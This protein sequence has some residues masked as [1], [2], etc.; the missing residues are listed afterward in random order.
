MV[1]GILIAPDWQREAFSKL[2]RLFKDASLLHRERFHFGTFF[3]PLDATREELEEIYGP[4]VIKEAK[5][6][7]ERLNANLVLLYSIGAGC[8]G[9]LKFEANYFSLQN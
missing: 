2:H 5:K 7:G 1:E 4:T 8:P 3:G 9:E 6:I